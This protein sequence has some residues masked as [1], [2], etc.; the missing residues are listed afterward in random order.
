MNKFRFLAS[1][2]VV[3]LLALPVVAADRQVHGSAGVGVASDYVFRGITQATDWVFESNVGIDV[4]LSDNLSLILGTNTVVF[5]SSAATANNLADWYEAQ[6]SIGVQTTVSDLYLGVTYV[7]YASPADAFATVQ[8]VVLSVVAPEYWLQPYAVLAIELN[9]TRG[10]SGDK[11]I[12]AEL[13]VAPTIIIFE[14]K[15]QP[16]TIILPVRVGLGLDGYYGGNGA[17]FGFASCGAIASTP[18]T[19]LPE[20]LGEWTI[21]TSVEFIYLGDNAK[22]LASDDIAIVGKFGIS[23]EF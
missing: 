11:A 3:C 4:E 20:A 17:E 8:E 22:A 14:S 23:T 12:Y 18:L 13:G 21:S 6:L 7:S 15:T 16:I 1:L 19:I 10:L 5:S 9:N 2:L